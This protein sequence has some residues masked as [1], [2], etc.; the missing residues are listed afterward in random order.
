M[1]PTIENGKIPL[2]YWRAAL[3]EVS[4]LHPEVPAESKPITL[5]NVN[6]AWKVIAAEP[7]VA[8]WVGAQFDA[9][10]VRTEG[11]AIRSIPFVLIAGRLSELASHG[12]KRGA[13]DVHK[14]LSVL[15]IPCLLD[16]SGTLLPDPDRHPWIPRDLLEP[17]LKSVAIGTLDSYDA[18]VSGLPGKATSFDDTLQIA[19]DLFAAVTE[20]RLPLL[21]S[22]DDDD[23][24]LPPFSLDGYK[25]V[26]AWHGIPYEPPVIARHLIKLYDQII[27]DK[28]SLPLLD[29][30]R[31]TTDRPSQRPIA[32][33][34]AEQWHAG[35]VGQINRQYPLSPS[36]REAMVE[37]AR[38][39]TGQV[40]AVNGPPGT[41]KTTLLQSVVAQVWVS[42][43]LRESE[44]PLIVVTSTNVKAVENVLDSFAKIGAETGHERWHSY[45][46]GFGLFLASESRESKHPTCTSKSH[47]FS[48]HET[49]DAVDSA[50]KYFL[51][52][53]SNYFE[54]EQSSVGDTVKEL[55]GLLTDVEKTLKKIVSVRY[56]VYR[57]TG[58]STADGAAS[59]CNALLILY[60]SR[61]DAEQS[62]VRDADQA[63][64]AC[65]EEEKAVERNHEA[66]RQAISEA[67]KNWQTYLTNSPLWLDLLSFLPP[68]RR[69]RDALDRQFLLSNPLTEDL[70]HRNDEIQ[71][72]FHRLR[73]AALEKKSPLLASITER[74]TSIKNRRN[75]AIKRRQS[76]EQAQ[77]KI[78]SILQ[79]WKEAIDGDDDMLDVSLDGLNDRLDTSFRAP[80]FSIADRY[81]TGRWLLEMRER[82]KTNKTDSK[83]PDRLEAKYRRFTK[84]SPC[85]V[86]NFHIA[87]SFFTAWRGTDIPLW[88]TID[89]LIVDEA[90]QVSPDIGAAMFAL[91]KRALVVGDIY[92]IEPV[93]NNGEGTDRA[94]ATKYELISSPRDP[95]YDTLASAGYTPANGNLM[96]MANRSCSV[97]KY[98][99][100]R[101]LML[102]EHRRC[103][104]ELIGYCNKLIYAN[105]LEPKRPGIKPADRLLPTFGYLEVAG[106]DKKAGGSR[107]NHDEAKSIVAW[108]K[109]NQARIE[110]HYRDERGHPKALWDLVGIITPFAAQAG[111]IERLLR[112]EMP[113]VMKK[114]KK[115]DQ[116]LTVGS[117][118]ALQGAER[119]IVIFSPTY[120]AT[121]KGGA[122]FD[123][124]PNMLNVAVSRAKDSFLVIGNLSLFDVAKPSLPSGLLAN[125]LFHGPESSPL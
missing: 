68:I 59:S 115:K 78:R 104:P 124:G 13:E 103:V 1:S 55:H 52:L 77:S 56:E 122:F 88:E 7:D 125:S 16:R 65:A 31:T 69:R 10:K 5:G 57:A 9:S 12:V 64:A 113:E 18:F 45:S 32:V 37:L 83:G 21:P 98:D 48:E 89:L 109:A 54:K 28:P 67:E 111:T 41:G 102:T 53:A 107:Q 99:D 70:Q 106:Q 96:R 72:H 23:N 29:S 49:A 26:S 17:T 25:L 58:Q 39:S 112:K 19:I 119:D 81:W 91:A 66:S 117:V 94:N 22:D 8:T 97:Q 60:Q 47:P 105:R 76:A 108:L 120:G 84:L 116:R 92:Q 33:Q 114:D 6:G 43:A 24:K 118:H 82:L 2:P 15:C 4:L 101:G 62:I 51:G 123:K 75:E 14:G 11:K 93:W 30:L 86:S 46:G 110:A 61:I 100:I 87:P 34:D 44:C 3:A 95:L 79:R 40:L 38:L 20:C 73:K 27:S 85:L 50:E 71:A 35:T 36:Q 80:M 42:A 74:R 63:L 90:G 121:Y